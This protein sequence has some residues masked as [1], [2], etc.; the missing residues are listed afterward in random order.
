MT[1][2]N[3]YASVANS[4]YL[5]FYGRPAD[6]AGLA[7][8]SQQLA[9]VDGELAD[10]TLAFSTSQE[11]QTRFGSDTLNERI[12]DI[13]QQLFNRAPDAAGLAYWSGAV[14]NGNATL[15]DVAI[16]ILGGAQGG[17]QSLSALR[18]KAADAFTAAVD[19]SDSG[20]SGYASIE[21]ARVLLRSVTANASETD[22]TALVRA[23]VSFADTA[24]KT[25]SVVDA[26]ASGST[27]LALF[28][29]ARGLGDPVALAQ[30]LA[31]TAKAAAGDVATLTQLLRGGGMAQVLKVMPA[32]ATL[33]DVV[34]ALAAGGLPAAIDVV[35]PPT[36]VPAPSRSID[37]SFAGVTQGDDDSVDDHV[38]NV[39][40]PDITFKYTG[41]DLVDGQHF[42]FTLNG[43]NWNVVDSSNVNTTN[44]TI[45]IPHLYIGGLLGRLDNSIQTY[46]PQPDVTTSIT[47]RA[48]QGSRVLD[49][50]QA[51]IVYD[52][53]API[54]GV[55]FVRLVGGADGVATTDEELVSAAFAIDGPLGDGIV[56]YRLA[57]SD[58]WTVLDP[59]DIDIDSDGVFTI[60]GI[61]LALADRTVEVR[62]IDAAGNALEP[63]TQLIDGPFSEVTPAFWIQPTLEGLAIGSN[64]AGDMVVLANSILTPVESLL[65]STR[66]TI[67]T[68]VVGAQDAVVSGTFTVMPDTGTLEQEALP[69]QIG[70]GTDISD[71]ISG[72]LVWGFDGA[73][74]I[75]SAS[76]EVNS[77]LDQGSYLFG[78]AGDDIITGGAGTDLI[79]GGAGADR[80]DLAEPEPADDRV[81][82][83]PGDTA[84]G[85]FIDGGSIEGMDVITGFAFADE[86]ELM[87]GVNNGTVVQSGYLT[88]GISN[89]WSIVRGSNASGS[90]T[91]GGRYSDNDYMVQ[92]ADGV[93]VNSFIINDYGSLTPIGL[94]DEDGRVLSFMTPDLTP[95]NEVLL[96]FNMTISSAIGNITGV[97]NSDGFG[98]EDVSSGSWTASPVHYYL[99]GDV[100]T[101]SDNFDPGLY[102]MYWDA[103]TFATDSGVLDAGGVQ[104]AGGS[105][106]S[107][108]H[109]IFLVDTLDVLRANLESAND[110][111][112]NDGYIANYN[113]NGRVHTG[114]GHDVVAENGAQLTLAYS[115]ID[116]T[117][118]DM[119]FGFD[120][121]DDKLLLE[122][123][124]AQALDHD[125]NGFIEWTNASELA[126]ES[127]ATSVMFSS[128]VVVSESANM[129]LTAATLSD[130]MNVGNIEIDDYLLIRAYDSGSGVQGAGVLYLFENMD[131][132]TTIS[133]GELT[134]IASFSGG[135]VEET[136]IELIG[137]PPG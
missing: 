32:N 35:Y 62:V 8:W 137:L 29:T 59:D 121:N 42:E 39:T 15:A 28:D 18:L 75:S 123:D 129:A 37:I 20:Y 128:R 89:D 72:N 19:A 26:I 57:G 82:F 117:S 6:P 47:M 67:G 126:F 98:F 64:F 83:M 78:G 84:T 2:Q 10:I 55:N 76:Q 34:A 120:T 7:F 102:L 96:S 109:E 125:H 90:F 119:V 38:T 54:V 48:V 45:T 43:V 133:A 17:D 21:A 136:D 94:L 106:G 127:E 58:A 92:W 68:T 118:Y 88:S 63:F 65:G 27:L 22:L 108:D 40:T 86:I 97:A 14:S 101:V 122:G 61:D 12:T 111:M 31:D 124:V 116:A 73:D 81:V 99:D 25:P 50:T 60:A 33:K 3:N 91:A 13:Y 93:N 44:N 100:I 80:I 69:F 51:Q 115:A 107:I 85:V 53:S 52:S 49:S 24:T 36:T 135:M 30:A 131:G 70:L 110:D 87:A 41:R 112:F 74:T 23:A 132:N 71:V 66:T 4:F 103:G 1:T 9:S 77:Q 56:Q 5:A 130:L 114:G 134:V 16:S 11:A 105:A 79:I 104:V 95:T 113:F 46:L